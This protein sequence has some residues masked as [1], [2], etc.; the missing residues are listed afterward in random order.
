VYR[1]GRGLTMVL[2]GTAALA[3]TTALA[4]PTHGIAMHGAP[5][6]PPGFSAFPYVRPD[7]P[8]GGRITLG[9][10]GSFD[11]LN[12]LIVRGS[13]AAGVRDLVVESLL[14]RSLDEPFTL[15]GLIAERIDVPD[16]RSAITFHLNP[17]A[18]F[19]DGRPV[20]A[21]DV[22]FS[23]ALLLKHG[24]PNLRTYYAKVKQVERLSDRSVLF[25]FGSGE[26]REIPLILGLMPV[27]P[28]HLLSPETFERTSLQPMV[29]SGPYVVANVDAG[30]SITYRANPEYW[31]RDLPVTRGRY[32]F[33]ELRFEY[34]R[35]ASALLEAFKIGQ[36]DLRVEEDPAMW[37]T[38]YGFPAVAEGR[39]VRTELPI[40]LPAGMSAIA[41][42]TRRDVLKDQRVRQALIRLFDFE[43]IN[44]N[45]YHGLT[46]RTESYFER[47][48]L[49]SHARPADARELALLKPFAGVVKPE[50]LDGTWSF[51]ISD[52]TGRNRDNQQAAVALLTG[53]GWRLSS[54]R[55]VDA[56]GRQLELEILAATRTQER[57]LVRYAESL[58]AL[59]IAARVRQVDSTQ[60]QA[61]LKTFDFD[62]I[63]AN[64]PSSLSP[65][66][67]QLF[68]WSTKAAET[69]G[70]FNYA[71]VKSPAVDAMIDAM[72]AAREPDAFVAAVRALDRV[73]LSG[74][75][76]VPLFHLPKQWIAYWN[77][78]KPPSRTPVFG[79]ALDSWW[80]EG[81]K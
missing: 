23:H 5:Q 20:T 67:E 60:Y 77:H 17:K 65:G 14:T 74:D 70:T 31:G 55:M 35:D 59:G 51:P 46:K 78:L 39:V 16:D 36:I 47:S 44:R 3:V 18:R 72:L 52:G 37:A 30:R 9:M 73:L 15:Y 40:A 48:V 76:V 2:L 42:N 22:I 62:M 64:W 33:A 21:D 12:P 54:G 81:E 66:N 57:L 63:Q 53:A 11:S 68:R 32:N 1:I 7:A 41:F 27:L 80:I 29:G 24:R 34:F 50:I 19:S 26:D 75:Y 69:E 13:A 58:K 45:L 4:E 71:G 25:S 79:Y 38:A 49:S 28:R 61:R 43:W 6:L 56:R 8:K 10:L